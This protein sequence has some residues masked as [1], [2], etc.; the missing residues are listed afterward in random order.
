MINF[1]YSPF[2]LIFISVGIFYFYYILLYFVDFTVFWMICFTL[3]NT[4]VLQNIL[5]LFLFSSFT[6]FFIAGFNFLSYCC[7]LV[8]TESG[9]S[10]DHSSS[11]I[12]ITFFWVSTNLLSIYYQFLIFLYFNCLASLLLSLY[13]FVSDSPTSLGRPLLSLCV[14]LVCVSSFY[15]VI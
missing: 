6:R 5:T 10:C 4:V 7:F 13:L 8:H 11:T 9:S 15:L 12:F 3:S 14:A 1:I 2:F